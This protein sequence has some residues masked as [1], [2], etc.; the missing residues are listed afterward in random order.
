VWSGIKT[1]FQQVDPLAAVERSERRFDPHRFANSVECLE[2]AR[3]CWC[4][5]RAF[6][7]SPALWRDAAWV[8]IALA[9][10]FRA[11]I[12]SKIRIAVST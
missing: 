9:R 2:I 3:A 12:C 8:T 6:V 1:A 7:T 5:C 10:S 4:S 11:P